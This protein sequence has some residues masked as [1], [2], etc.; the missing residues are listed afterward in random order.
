MP[1]D[2]LYFSIILCRY[3]FPPQYI[4]SVCDYLKMLRIY[5]GWIS[6]KMI[7]EKS[8]RDFSPEDYIAYPMCKH[9]LSPSTQ[10][11]ITLFTF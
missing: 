1:M 4:F 7:E 10:L 11:P 3:P 2:T 5:T 8:F 6:T 9:E